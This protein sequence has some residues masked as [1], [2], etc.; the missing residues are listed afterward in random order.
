MTVPQD[1]DFQSSA[2][3]L[4]SA[5]YVSPPSCLSSPIGS[6]A[7]WRAL[8][9]GQVNIPDG[10]MIGYLKTSDLAAGRPGF[11]FWCQAPVGSTSPITEYRVDLHINGARITRWYGGFSGV[12]YEFPYKWHPANNVWYLVRVT[13]WFQCTINNVRR[14]ATTFEYWDGAAWVSLGTHYET[15]GVESTSLVNRCGV[16]WA[17]GPWAFNARMQHD[18]TQLWLPAP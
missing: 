16:C 17:S 4:Y 9:R 1:W 15:P 8:Y 7:Y 6:V 10:Q 2:W 5:D 11:C 3:S 18:D 13:W 12:L 14:A